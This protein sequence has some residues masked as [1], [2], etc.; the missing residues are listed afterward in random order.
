[1]LL[2]YSTVAQVGYLFLLYPLAAETH[3]GAGAW[4]GGVYY[5]LSHACAKAAVFMTAGIIL[6]VRGTDEIG[7][8]RGISEHLPLTVMTFATAGIALMGLPPS[9]GFTGKWLLLAAAIES[10]QWWYSAVVVAGGLLAAGYLLRFLTPAFTV[11]S[12]GD[13][14]ERPLR[15]PR[16]LEV[17]A[18][19][20]ALLA[21]LLGLVSSPLVELLR[22]GAPFPGEVF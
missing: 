6:E 12:P 17:P 19:L 21:L 14:R 22:I 1:M 8:L 11:E 3:W 20:L 13:H 10:G 16:A 4:S 5:A 7:K 9:G 15:A 2:A 18:F